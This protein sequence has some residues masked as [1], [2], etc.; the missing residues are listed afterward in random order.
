MINDFR[1]SRSQFQ[2]SLFGF[3]FTGSDVVTFLDSQSTFDVTKM[4]EKEFHL[5]T[6]L[7]PQ[8]KLETYGWLVKDQNQYSF[9]VPEKIIEETRSRLNRFLVS[10]D[11]EIEETGIANWHYLLGNS[12]GIRGIIF[13]EDCVLSKVSGDS[14]VVPSSEVELWRKLSGWPSFDGSDYSR[15]LVT[16]LR[17]FDL[18]VSMNKGCYPGQETVSKIATRRGAAYSPV[19][20]ETNEKISSGPVLIS[21]NKIGTAEESLAWNEKFYSPASLLRDFRVEGMK[22]NFEAGGNQLQGF[23]RY[24][25][26]LKGSPKEKAQE[27]YDS[28]LSYFRSD[29][30]VHA[31][32]DLRR[33]LDFDPGFAD[34]YEALGVML[35]RQD[36]YPEAI[37]LMEKLT[38]V[39]PDSSMA[40]T[41][42]SLFLMKTGKIEEA[43]NHKSMATMK[44]FKKFGD[45]AKEKEA[46]A[47]RA[48][49]E[50]EEWARREK[51]FREVLEIDPEDT[52]ANYGL[53]SIAVE[54][55]DWENARTFLESVLKADPK[56]SVAY[57]ALG[58]AY[59]GLGLSAKAK[60]TF[61]EGIKVAAAKG[62]FMP[63]N[64]MQSEID[65]I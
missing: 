62:D 9:L 26:L 50:L 10:E 60:D 30:L 24:Y 1:F 4:G 18:A 59:K 53:G 55:G 40:H 2:V 33:A 13:D 37:T 52:L 25:P 28:G 8:G 5:A 48:K 38:L 61:S 47:Q 14:S 15:E 43:E 3:S 46:S 31:E 42:L 44:S 58:R 56:Y 27:L 49:A 11:V 41:N 54:K 32:K 16:N 21:G 7:D 20:I 64:Q 17:L 65:R 23:V 39:D 12:E 63:A 57:L 36:R 34:A 22:L 45:E 19:L 51:M 35:G 6:F 29:D